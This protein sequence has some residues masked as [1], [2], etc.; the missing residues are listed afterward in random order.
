MAVIGTYPS[1]VSLT[2]EVVWMALN[3][4]WGSGDA[5][6]VQQ[7]GKM[8]QGLSGRA[9]AGPLLQAAT[10]MNCQSRPEFTPACVVSDLLQALEKM[11]CV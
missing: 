7:L 1:Q 9:A 8:V 5:D 2:L 3:G 10:A 11:A 6:A 4:M